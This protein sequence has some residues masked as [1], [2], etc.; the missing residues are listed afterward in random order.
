[1]TQV[2]SQAL[3]KVGCVSICYVMLLL[4]FIVLS[5][6][7]LFTFWPMNDLLLLTKIIMT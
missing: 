5:I 2:T 1:M 4:Y 6:T 3:Q 7:A